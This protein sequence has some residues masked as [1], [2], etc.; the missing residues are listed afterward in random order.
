MSRC[1]TSEVLCADLSM[2]RV[3]SNVDS[4]YTHNSF[5]CSSDSSQEVVDVDGLF[6]FDDTNV[7][8]VDSSLLMSYEDMFPSA[9]EM[10]QT[11]SQRSHS[12]TST[13]SSSSSRTRHASRSQ[14]IQARR[15]VPLAP[16]MERT[17][18]GDSTKSQQP[19]TITVHHEDGS[20]SQKTAISPPQKKEE[21]K[22]TIHCTFCTDHPDG[23]HGDHELRRHMERTHA[24]IR[25]VWVCVDKSQD[26]QFLANC[27]ACRNGKTYG[28]N[29]NAAA[30]LRRTHFKPCQNKRGSRVKSSEKRAGIGGGNW[31]PMEELKNW[32]KESFEHNVNGISVLPMEPMSVSD[33]SSEGVEQTQVDICPVY[34]NFTSEQDMMF[35]TAFLGH[36]QFGDEDL[37]DGIAALYKDADASTTLLSQDESHDLYEY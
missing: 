31:P 13:S 3:N 7:P 10:R 32:M 4:K 26:G 19:Q 24:E 9:P 34:D 30:H 11:I 12:S 35:D 15:E 25:K 33:S 20:T 14:Q 36:D 27:K 23:F 18:S 37:F 6:P 21:K 5:L 8:T 29:Y 2:F 28:A 1:T 16:K 17:D 22:K